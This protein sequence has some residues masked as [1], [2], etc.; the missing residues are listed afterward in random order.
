M[1]D[2]IISCSVLVG[3]KTGYAEAGLKVLPEHLLVRSKESYEKFVV[4]HHMR[5]AD[6]ILR[7]LTSAVEK[8]SFRIKNSAVF[9]FVVGT[10]GK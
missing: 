5:N 4:K 1:I 10:S 3:T 6:L 8:V 7:L 9:I 2:Q